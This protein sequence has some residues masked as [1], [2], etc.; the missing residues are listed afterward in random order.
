M[1]KSHIGAGAAGKNQAVALVYESNSVAPRVIAKGEGLLAEAILQKATEAGI[2]LKAEPELVA[3]LM[4]I[5][6]NEYIPPALYKAVAE[7]IAWVYQL[8]GDSKP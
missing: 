8:S 5:E 7:V 6:I 2:P 3:L 4:Q 1:T